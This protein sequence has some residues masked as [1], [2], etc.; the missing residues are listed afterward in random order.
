MAGPQTGPALSGV[1]AVDLARAT[2]GRW[3]DG[4]VG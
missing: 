1:D 2:L 3:V 4:P